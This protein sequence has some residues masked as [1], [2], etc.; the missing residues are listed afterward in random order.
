[1][2]LLLCDVWNG[3]VYVWKKAKM[4]QIWLTQTNIVI[5][6]F[7]AERVGHCVS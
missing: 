6:L 7:C 1:M 4:S 3:Y 2:L 5:V